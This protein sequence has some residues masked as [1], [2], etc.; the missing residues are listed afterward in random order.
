MAHLSSHSSPGIDDE[1]N[2]YQWIR[3]FYGDIAPHT[4]PVPARYIQSFCLGIYTLAIVCTFTY[5]TCSPAYTFS[6]PT[7]FFPVYFQACKGVSPNLSGIYTLSLC[8]RASCGRR[9]SVGRSDRQ[10]PAP[11][12]GRVSDR[13][14]HHGLIECQWCGGRGG[15]ERPRGTWSSL[16]LVRGTSLRRLWDLVLTALLLP[17]TGY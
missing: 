8:I 7:D 4:D 15:S 6:L 10:I 11:D 1:H 16:T 2:H 17:V 14:H 12:V 3:D 5:L 9:W 13:A